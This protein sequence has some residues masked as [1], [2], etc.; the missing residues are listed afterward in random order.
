MNPYQI[1]PFNR[2]VAVEGGRVFL[3]TLDAALIALDARTGLPLW[4]NQIAD[5]ML[6]Y[7]L[8]S[9]P[10]VVN[11]KVIVGVSGGEFGAPGF[12][13]A[14]DVANGK[15]LWRFNTVPGPGE[16][17]HDSWA[18]DSWKRGGAPAWL[19]GSYD[20]KTDTLYWGIGNPG[21]DLNSDVRAGDNLFSCSV[22]ALDASTGKRKW[23]YQF[24][25]GDSHDWD[26][27]EDLVLVDRTF[28]GEQRS[29]LLQANRNGFFYALDREKGKFLQAKAFVRQ[30]WNKGFDENGRP[31]FIPDTKATPDGT[32]V[33]PGLGGG[34]NWQAPSYD[35]DKGL[36]Y[37]AFH[38]SGMEFVSLD[39]KFEPGKIFFGRGRGTGKTV[40]KNETMS[41]GVRALDPETGLSKWEYKIAGP[42]SLAA[43]VLGTAGGLVFSS[44]AEGN[45]IALDSATGKD[46]WHFQTGAVI[47][48]SPMS[49]AV[50]GKQF[51]AVAAGNVLYTFALPE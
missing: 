13:E 39:E 44:T 40:P 21:P 37:I 19:T 9:A 38:D 50:D 14:Y 34:T 41:A 24:S 20:P 48:S 45:L 17:G 10:L 32:F 5:T 1:N 16:F 2:G 30:S 47:A 4:E 8:T 36:L 33:Y 35:A 46:L 42:Q 27:T 22:V 11:G 28:H 6:G 3:G 23:H 7:T 49:Y 12:V 43:G 26:A 29:L 31:I 15:Q 18:G 51:I 25:P